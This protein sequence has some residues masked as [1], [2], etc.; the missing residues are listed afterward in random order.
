MNWVL[1][2]KSVIEL[3]VFHEKYMGDVFKGILYIIDHRYRHIIC[4]RWVVS[5]FLDSD[6]LIFF[7][8]SSSSPG[9]DGPRKE[10]RV[11]SDAG[12]VHRRGVS[13]SLHNSL[14]VL[15]LDKAPSR[16]LLGQQGKLGRS[17][18]KGQSISLSVCMSVC[19][20]MICQEDIFP[21]LSPFHST[22]ERSRSKKMSSSLYVHLPDRP[23]QIRRATFQKYEHKLRQST[24][25]EAEQLW[26]GR[27]GL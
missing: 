24:G 22:I 5:I 18:R 26:K 25:F 14:G 13:T 6:P 21:A 1:Q 2:K 20:S 23:F 4:I 7:T 9:Y 12:G 16:R 15:P 19:Q 17:C 27:S 3:G 11:A 10:R 8:P